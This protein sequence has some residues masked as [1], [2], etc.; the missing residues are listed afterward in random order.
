VSLVVAGSARSS[1]RARLHPMVS[2]LIIAFAI[3]WLSFYVSNGSKNDANFVPLVYL[4]PIGSGL[5][6]I[7]MLATNRQLRMPSF[8]A[9]FAGHWMNR[10]ERRLARV[11]AGKGSGS[12]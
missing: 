8:V 3:R 12:P 11:T 5:I 2:A 6:A 7:F 4:V 1:R 10:A 9:N